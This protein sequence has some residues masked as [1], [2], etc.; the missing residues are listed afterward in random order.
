MAD[1]RHGRIMAD[2]RRVLCEGVSRSEF[3]SRVFGPGGLVDRHFPADRRV[4]ERSRTYRRLSWMRKACEREPVHRVELR[5]PVSLY[6]R[7][8]KEAGERSLP[9]AHL[10]LSRCRLTRS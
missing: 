10:I 5:I 3:S 2:A 6:R 4:F 9:V 8:R 1:E 7:L